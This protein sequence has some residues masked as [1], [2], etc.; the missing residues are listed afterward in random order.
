MKLIFIVLGLFCFLG[1]VLYL[2]LNQRKMLYY[3]QPLD[4]EWEHVKQ[5]V[6]FEY[7]FERDGIKLHGW[8]IYPEREKLLIYYGGNGEEA[9]QLIGLFKELDEVA[10]LL[11][12]YRG[13][14]ESGGSPTETGL[15]GD[16]LAIFDD[17]RDRFDSITLLGRSLGSGIAVQVAAQRSIKRLILVTPYDSIAAV[18]QGMYPWAPV[19]WLAKDPFDSLAASEQVTCSAL[20]LIAEFDAIIPQKHS[21]NLFENWQGN[22]EWVVV[23]GSD[24]NSII[25]F[26]A[27]WNSL[28]Q[29][30]DGTVSTENP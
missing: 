10:V 27:Y 30:L 19:K 5:N 14:G 1:M 25:E 16:A 24:H 29:Y 20:F 15:V 22:K 17:V 8:L 28:K 18:G 6:S 12:N 21:Q 2:Y 3:P 7:R 4:R 11:V 23:Q 26:P 13:Y 9:S